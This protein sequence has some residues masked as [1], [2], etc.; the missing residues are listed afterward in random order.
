MITARSMLVLK[1]LKERV[2]YVLPFPSFWIP[3]TTTINLSPT[4]LKQL[5]P[6]LSDLAQRSAALLQRGTYTN[7][8]FLKTSWKP[9]ANVNRCL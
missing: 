6:L 3:D 2:K 5:E 7:V 8:T 9:F 1:N 4:L